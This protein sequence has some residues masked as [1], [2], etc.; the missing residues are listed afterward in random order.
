MIRVII[1]IIIFLALALLSSCIHLYQSA[2][3]EAREEGYKA[4]HANGYRLAE[5]VS[6]AEVT[7]KTKAASEELDRKTGDI[8]AKAV[9]DAH[10]EL[11][12]AM[13]D[14][15]EVY[16][17]FIDS[18]PAKSADKPCCICADLIGWSC[19]HGIG[20]PHVYCDRHQLKKAATNE[21]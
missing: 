9:G 7:R 21:T 12:V 20:G 6:R 2:I 1:F 15:K 4:G 10:V 3:D 8:R 19:D 5:A 13:R 11:F 18:L 14:N 17:K 16:H